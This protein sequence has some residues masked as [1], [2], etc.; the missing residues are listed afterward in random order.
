M[1][2][3]AI[4]VCVT[5]ASLR[6]SEQDI[7]EGV[8]SELLAIEIRPVLDAGPDSTALGK[9]FMLR[10]RGQFDAAVQVITAGLRFA[11]T[12]FR[13]LF[14]RGY[15]LY[16]L[17]RYDKALGDYS[18]AW[19]LCAQAAAPKAQ[20]SPTPLVGAHHGTGSAETVAFRRSQ[21]AAASAEGAAAGGGTS[22][23]RMGCIVVR[24]NMALW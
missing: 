5:E 4:H 19:A 10:Q 9:A 18:A 17:A 24:W 22:W 16:N 11:P 2:K 12:D 20:P 23:R 7:A 13:L 3:L 14:N 1:N 6:E 8:G 21:A 15:L